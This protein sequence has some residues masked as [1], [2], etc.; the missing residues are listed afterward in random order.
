MSKNKIFNFF[1]G[2]ENKSG[3]G[4]TKKQ[5]ERDKKMG[6]SFFFRLLKNR[7]ANLSSTSLFFSLC[8]FPIFLF[9]FGIS[10]NLDHSVPAPSTPLYAQLY[11]LETAGETSPLLAALHGM[12]GINATASIVSNGSKILMYSAL[13]L[14]FTF[15]LSTIGSV[16]NF[17]SII[18]CDPLSPWSEAFSSIRRNFRQGFPIAILDA[19]VVL[20]L[21][22]DLMAYY[23]NAG[24]F[25]MQILFDII[26]FFSLVYFMMRS[27]IYL[28]LITFDMKLSKVLKNA[29]LLTFL[30]WKRSLLC[31]LTSAATIL[32]SFFIYMLLPYF[33]ILLPFVFTFGFL[34]YTGVYFAYPIIE[35]YMIEPYYREHP[36]E[37]PEEEEVETIFQDRG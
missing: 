36:E 27:Y 24:N 7:L 13:L 16:Y 18:R 9:L 25:M 6:V 34:I 17:R 35:K 1:S 5:V 31:I 22:Y 33:G 28:I 14:I 3:R 29:F 11:G 10:G 30:G 37:L 32:I 21:G 8:N 23:V 20:F 15:G 26:L 19:V 2:S 4:V 12:F